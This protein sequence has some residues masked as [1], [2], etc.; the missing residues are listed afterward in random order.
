MND[1]NPRNY[2]RQAEI[3]LAALSVI[4]GTPLGL[5]GYPQLRAAPSGGPTANVSG[6]VPY[7]YEVLAV[8]GIAHG[9]IGWFP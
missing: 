3:L 4:M 7:P 1:D 8:D 2:G 5:A 6:G 9:K